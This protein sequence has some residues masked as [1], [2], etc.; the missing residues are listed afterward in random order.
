MITVLITAHEGAVLISRTMSAVSRLYL[1]CIS[2]VSRQAL[3]GARLGGA[4]GL[5]VDEMATKNE[6]DAL[7][8]DVS[9]MLL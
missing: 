2:R 1:G 6:M 5:D 8:H 3:V 7:R 9:H 4:A